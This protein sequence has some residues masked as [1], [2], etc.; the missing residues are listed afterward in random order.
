MT[1]LK[2]K[3]AAFEDREIYF[4]QAIYLS[5]IELSYLT[6]WTQSGLPVLSVS[7]SSIAAS[8]LGFQFDLFLFK[9]PI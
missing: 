8:F 2:H 5:V 9:F 6:K 1:D 3:Y 7:A 4:V